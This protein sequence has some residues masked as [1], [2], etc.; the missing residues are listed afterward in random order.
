MNKEGVDGNQLYEQ[1]EERPGN[2]TREEII[3]WSPP[4]NYMTPE[5]PRSICRVVHASFFG[6][7]C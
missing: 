2:H 5:W 3:N 7:N 1:E 4:S 6:N